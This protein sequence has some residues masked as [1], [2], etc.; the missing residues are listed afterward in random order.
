MGFVRCGEKSEFQ[1]IENTYKCKYK[2]LICDDYE[3]EW[4]DYIGIS[5]KKV[6]FFACK[7][8]DM[9]IGNTGTIKTDSHSA[10]KFHDVVA[11]ALKKPRKFKSIGISIET[12]DEAAFQQLWLLSS[13]ASTCL[14]AGITPKVICNE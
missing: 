12:K 14:E 1:L 10:S 6:T 4:A 2:C 5:S 7:H 8:A 3:T 11:Q 13:F 9:E